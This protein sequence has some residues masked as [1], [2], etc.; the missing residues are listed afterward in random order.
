VFLRGAG[1]A[2]SQIADT[3]SDTVAQ[4]DRAQDAS[5]QASIGRAVV[6]ARTLFAEQGTFETDPTELSAFDPSIRFT[7]GA[8][9]GPTSISYTASDS[10]FGIAVRSESG[11]CWWARA[12]AA[13]GTTYGSGDTCTGE[14]A[15]AA[16]APGW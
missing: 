10:S 11:T 1:E 9:T 2:G 3:R 15:L 6:V 13:G 4:I 7:T 14:S 8:S 12:D 16:N 5:A